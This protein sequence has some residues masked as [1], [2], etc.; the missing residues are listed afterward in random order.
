MG[1]SAGDVIGVLDVLED[2]SI[3]VSVAGGWAVDALL[4]RVT[5]EHGDLDLAIDTAVVDEAVAALGRVG[6]RSELDVRPARLVLGDGRRAVDLHPIAWGL[7]GTGTQEGLT[8]ERFTYP[9]GSTDAVGHIES[10]TVR[11]LTPALLIAF[12]LHYEPRPVDRHDM[13]A[14]ARRFDLELPPPY[15]TQ[16]IAARDA[17]GA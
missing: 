5:R 16:R 14:L 7:D 13:A 6:L 9:P 10:R 3:P 1:M 17:G 4:G 11:C 2:G 15:W 8:G 12:H